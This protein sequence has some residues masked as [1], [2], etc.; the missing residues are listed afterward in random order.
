MV[1]CPSV[2]LVLLFIVVSVKGTKM[3]F[4]SFGPEEC[5]MIQK[6]VSSVKN[7]SSVSQGVCHSLFSKSVISKHEDK[8]HADVK[9]LPLKVSCHCF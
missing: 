6:K 9:S 3:L 4:F 8:N 1:A 7:N 2:D 5:R